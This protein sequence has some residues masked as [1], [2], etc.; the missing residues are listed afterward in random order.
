MSR[1]LIALESGNFNNPANAHNLYDGGSPYR[2]DLAT[3]VTNW[4]SA[5]G[6]DLKGGL[7]AAA[8]AAAASPVAA[9][10]P[11]AAPAAPTMALPTEDS[12]PPTTV[13]PETT[14]ALTTA[15]PTS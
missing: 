4:S 14:P 1:I 9:A 10:P 12:M 11:P 15:Y 2:D 5:T 7:T 8:P 3:I 6:R 13:S